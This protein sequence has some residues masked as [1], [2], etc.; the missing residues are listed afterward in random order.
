M[1]I[2]SD[3]SFFCLYDLTLKKNGVLKSYNNTGFVLNC[4]INSSSMYLY[5]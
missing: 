2:N 1:S 4:V 3:I 5:E